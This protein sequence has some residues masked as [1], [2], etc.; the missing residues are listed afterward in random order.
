MASMEGEMEGRSVVC[1]AATSG[2]RPPPPSLSRQSSEAHTSSPA[3][4]GKLQHRQGQAF[5]LGTN[6]PR[7]QPI[8]LVL[9]S[10]IP[11]KTL[12]QHRGATPKSIQAAPAEEL[13]VS[14]Y[15]IVKLVE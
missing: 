15:N 5:H 11:S 7:S 9:T 10:H 6:I 12:A 3:V 8:K 4:F 2:M 14:L 1:Y 13:M